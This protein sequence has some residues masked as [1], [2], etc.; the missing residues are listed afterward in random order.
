MVVGSR[1]GDVYALHLSDGS[2][3]AGWPFNTGAPVDST[4]SVAPIGPFGLD[5][6]FVGSGNAADP[7][8]G[9]YTGISNSGGQLWNVQTQNPVGCNSDT[10]VQASLAVGNL[11]DG[12]DVVAGSLGMVTYALDAYNGGTRPGYPWLS[13]DSV[14]STAAMA[15]LYRNGGTEIVVGGDSTAGLAGGQTYTNGG[16]LRVL[17]G[18]GNLNCVY[19]TDQVV[20]ASPAVGQFQGTSG[21]IGIV[22]GTGT[23]YPGASDTDRLIATDTNCNPLWSTVLPGATNSSP[24]LADVLGNGQDQIIE[25]SNVNNSSGAVSVVDGSDGS[26]I[27]TAA[28]SNPVVGSVVT[29]DLTGQGYQDILAPT[30]LGVD[31]FDGRS[32]QQVATLAPNYGFQNSPL[33]TDDADGTIGVTLAGYYPAGSEILH[34]EFPGTDGA[35]ADEAGAWPMFHHDPQL[36]GT[37]GSPDPV[38]ISGISP[39]SGTTAGRTTVTIS[40]S[41]LANATSVDFDNT[42]ATV[43]SD[44]ATSITVLTPPG[45]AGPTFVTVT[46]DGQ[47]ALAPEVYTYFVPPPPTITSVSPAR[48]P[49]AG[50]TI[51]TITGTNLESVG[52]VSF[53]SGGAPVFTDPDS[54]GELVVVTPAGA[55][56]PAPV[57]VST[58]G[59]TTIDSGGFTYVPPV[60]DPYTPVTPVRICDTRPGN[61]SGLTGPAAQCDGS[62]GSGETLVGSTVSVDVAG[63]FGVPA[64]A[65]AVMLNVTAA[66]A[67]T[68]G[69][70]TAFPTDQVPPSASSV[71]FPAGTAVPNLVEVA[72]GAGGG[73]RSPRTRWWTW[74]WTS[75]ATWLRRPHRGP[76]STTPSPHRRASVTPGRAIRRASRGRPPSVTVDRS[77]R[78]R[79]PTSRSRGSG[80]SRPPGSRP[81]CSTSRWW[82]RRT[83]D[84]SRCTRRT[85]RHP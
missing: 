30:T 16:H 53:G 73:C 46:A 77:P 28:T 39:A 56:G 44:S 62:S 41:Y 80:G 40:G 72:V 17:T 85:W 25:G 20:Q 6:V 69:Y 26:V 59:G 75:R 65:T 33:V 29:A 37:A 31:V 51:V 76:G 49:T 68:S 21:N 4:P 23:Y 60:P 67:W 24:A 10:G 43:L 34:Y 55:A 11:G 66:D 19:N 54:G 27:W 32:G 13:A 78:P 71:N 5:D 61:P 81:P 42:P 83:G 15:D 57:T 2:G 84:I 22:F 9:G 70:V 14:F 38:T 79:R 18:N 3:V 48:G 64:D 50:R 45:A 7:R 12:A 35:A 58:V 52:S 8:S 47:V 82:A 74:W 1:D 63:S 36:A